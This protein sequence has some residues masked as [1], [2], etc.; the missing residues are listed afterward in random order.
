MREII[1]NK[2]PASLTRH[3][4]TPYADYDNYVEKESL[5]N[6]LVEEQR[7]LCCYCLSRIKSNVMKIEHWHCQAKYS[8]EQLDYQNLLGVCLGNEGHSRR[9]Q[10]CDTRKGD[11]DLS[12]NPANP[13]HKVEDFIRFRSDGHITS[14]DPTFNQE[15]NDVLNLNIA[16]LKNQRKEVLNAFTAQLSRIPGKMPR[17]KL[18]KWLREWNGESDTSEL[19]PFCQVIVYWL[20]KRLKRSD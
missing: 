3:R 16:L 7:G 14:D 13:E 17:T 6:S 20:R 10:H 12:R 1:K 18:E 11:N 2:E 4:T 9:E 5:R 19:K 15:L 8:N